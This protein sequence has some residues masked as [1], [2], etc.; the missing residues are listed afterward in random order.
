MGWEGT[1][2]SAPWQVDLPR[3]AFSAVTYYIIARSA[4]A[5]DWFLPS[6]SKIFHSNRKIPYSDY[7]RQPIWNSIP[8]YSILSL[9]A[10]PHF[11][12]LIARYFPRIRIERQSSNVLCLTRGYYLFC[13]PVPVPEVMD[14]IP[15]PSTERCAAKGT[16][17]WD[18]CSALLTCWEKSN[19]YLI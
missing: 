3:I 17:T 8:A 2:L 5:C 11:S 12:F 13:L 6:L 7:W 4:H 15:T 14:A 19:T 9:S 16:I 1:R 18:S 10:S